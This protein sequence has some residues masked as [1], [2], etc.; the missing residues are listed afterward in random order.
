MFGATYRDTVNFFALLLAKYVPQVLNLKI[1]SVEA[2]I[3]HF[4]LS[5][6][7]HVIYAPGVPIDEL[8]NDF[9]VH[10]IITMEELASLPM[11]NGDDLS[12]SSTDENE[13]DITSIYHTSG[14]TAGRPKLIKQ[15]R[16]WIDGNARKTIPGL[17]KETDIA[18]MMNGMAHVSQLV[19]E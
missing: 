15:T 17:T 6:I 16:R 1:Q 2:A 7:A 9:K 3:F 8:R 12:S 13:Q 19:G 4:K 5:D 14:S 11:Q 10:K 18:L